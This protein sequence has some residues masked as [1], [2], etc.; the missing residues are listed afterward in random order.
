MRSALG[1]GI[2]LDSW[3]LPSFLLWNRMGSGSRLTGG[4]AFCHWARNFIFDAK[5][6]LNQGRQENRP[7]RTEKLL[8]VTKSI[9]TNRQTHI[10]NTILRMLKFQFEQIKL[11][12]K[13]FRIFHPY[14]WVLIKYIWFISL[15]SEELPTWSF[16][17]RRHAE[18]YIKWRLPCMLTQNGII[19]FLFS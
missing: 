8:T 14:D 16:K 9:N 4:T 15:W 13:N 1:Q 7:D 10:N 17:G 2:L 5:C 12:N 18:W 19:F 6:W 11:L 3:S